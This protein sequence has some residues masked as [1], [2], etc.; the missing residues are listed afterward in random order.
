MQS[1]K[2]VEQLI[3]AIDRA[4]L[5]YMLVGSFASNVFGITRSTKDAD[6]VVE[7]AGRKISDITR[8]LGAGYKLDP[9]MRFE[10]V[11]GTSRFIIE[12]VGSPFLLEIFKLSEDP[13]D[14]ERFARRMRQFSPEIG[15]DVFLLTAED[16]IIT[17]LRWSVALNRNK[18]R[19]DARDVMAVQGDALDWPYIYGWCDR[20]GTRAL[21]DEVRASIPPID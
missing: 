16:V 15:R 21:L 9:Q 4:G 17:K 14:R 3:D 20:H 6:V 18:D 8:N 10:S 5:P 2:F 11:T 7:F 19:D 13:H 12:V 1:A